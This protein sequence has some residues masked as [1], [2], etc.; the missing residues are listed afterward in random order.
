MQTLLFQFP[1]SDCAD[2]GVES[3]LGVA[4]KERNDDEDIVLSEKVIRGIQNRQ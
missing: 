1:N 3:A 2:G 4:G